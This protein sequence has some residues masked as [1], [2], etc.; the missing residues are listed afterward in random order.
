MRNIFGVLGKLKRAI[1]SRQQEGPV[2]NFKGEL[3][4]SLKGRDVLGTLLIGGSLVMEQRC[5]KYNRHSGADLEII[6]RGAQIEVFVTKGVAMHK[7]RTPA[8]RP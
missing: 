2:Q 8:H 1:T 7:I 6:L 5:P 3:E 4:R